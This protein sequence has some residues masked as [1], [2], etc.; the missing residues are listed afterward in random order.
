MNRQ[1]IGA[2]LEQALP[3]TLLQRLSLHARVLERIRSVLPEPLRNQ[4]SDCVVNDKGQI[5]VYVR[6]AAYGAQ[7]RFYGGKMLEALR[8]G[9]FPP[10]RQVVVRIR[11]EAGRN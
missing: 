11:P 5:V 2:I 8:N 7:I 10:L 9:E 1:P 6:N 3:A 4:C